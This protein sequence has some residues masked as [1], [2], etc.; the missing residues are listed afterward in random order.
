MVALAIVCDCAAACG[1]MNDFESAKQRAKRENKDIMLSF[2]GY[3]W[4]YPT[5][6]IDTHTQGPW[7]TKHFIMLEIEIPRDPEGSGGVVTTEDQALIEIR[8]K[9]HQEIV[10]PGPTILLLDSDGR[11]YAGVDHNE[12]PAEAY[13]PDLKE[14]IQRRMKR[15]TAFRRG[16]KEDGIRK[17]RLQNEGLLALYE[18][19]VDGEVVAWASQERLVH[20]YYQDVLADIIGNDP[21]DVLG[22]GRELKEEKQWQKEV[23]EQQVVDGQLKTLATDLNRMLDA[24]SPLATIFSAI[25]KF[26]ESNPALSKET[27]QRALFGKVEAAIILRDYNVALIALDA[28]AS[29][30]P[31][32]SFTKILE[33]V[34]RSEILKAIQLSGVGI[35]SAATAYSISLTLSNPESLL[36]SD[37]KRTLSELRRMDKNMD[38]LL[39]EGQMNRLLAKAR[40]LL[41][42][43]KYEQSLEALDAFVDFGGSSKMVERRD[44]ELRP[45]IVRGLNGTSSGV[46]K[47]PKAEV[48]PPD[49]P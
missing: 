39:V 29:F 21:N 19:M 45:I 38:A 27:R 31:D 14:A 15:D 5:I 47:T 16:Q 48:V 10:E 44:R 13:L 9:F 30:G 8:R 25:D 17:A 1:P 22:R 7:L 28:T 46:G 40:L 23:A 41:R 33:T 43:R 36:D 12:Q 2:S 34:L 37:G 35:D 26:L 18:I 6:G 3:R 32:L 20:D 42:L 11:P 24:S 4:W 49:G